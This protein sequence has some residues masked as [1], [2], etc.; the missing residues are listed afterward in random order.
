MKDDDGIFFLVTREYYSDD[1]FFGSSSKNCSIFEYKKLPLDCSYL[2][3]SQSHLQ[4]Q[5]HLSKT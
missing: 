5:K 3:I 1:Y 2:A 4:F